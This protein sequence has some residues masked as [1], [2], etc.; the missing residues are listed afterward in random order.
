M[1]SGIRSR[2][3]LSAQQKAE[4]DNTH[5]DLD[6]LGC[7]KTEFLNCFIVRCFEENDDNHTRRKEPEL[8][9]LVAQSTDYGS[10]LLTDN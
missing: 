4:V 3:V 1:I 5:R 7:Y 10:Y 6:Y 8:L 9:L 2:Q